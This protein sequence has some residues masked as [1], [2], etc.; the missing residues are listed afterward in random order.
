MFQGDLA[1]RG[2]VVV[3]AV[4]EGRRRPDDA[5]GVFVDEGLQRLEIHTVVVPERH[6]D[7]LEPEIVTPSSKGRMAGIGY[8]DLQ[9]GGAG[10]VRLAPL[11]HGVQST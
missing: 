7:P 1:Q 4:G 2:Y 10:L 9:P 8:Q 3:A 11:A 5:D 6:L